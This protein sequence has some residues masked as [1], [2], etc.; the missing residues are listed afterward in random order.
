MDN[1]HLNLDAPDILQKQLFA[2][3][4]AC[5]YDTNARM[6]PKTKEDFLEANYISFTFTVG[7]RRAGENPTHSLM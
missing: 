1:K 4:V 2:T 3:K 5:I 7:R 6:P